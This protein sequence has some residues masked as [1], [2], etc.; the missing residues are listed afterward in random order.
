MVHNIYDI[1]LVLRANPTLFSSSPIGTSTRGEQKP[2]KTDKFSP[3]GSGSV[4]KFKIFGF[5][6]RNPRVVLILIHSASLKASL[7]ISPPSLLSPHSL[8]PNQPPSPPYPPPPYP[9]QRRRRGFPFSSAS[10]PSRLPQPHP[11]TLTYRV[12][13]L[14]STSC[15][16]TGASTAALTQPHHPSHRAPPPIDDNQHISALSLN[17]NTDRRSHTPIGPSHRMY[18]V[19]IDRRR[20]F[21]YSSSTIL[22]LQ[23]HFGRCSNFWKTLLQCLLLKGKTTFNS[24]TLI[25]RDM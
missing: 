3:F 10:P 5:R 18:D 16:A 1:F 20:K 13:L 23:V 21:L 11:K 8:L 25:C 7:S 17:P 24:E 12:E 4:T 9:A 6:V 15:Y 19:G 14:L 2:E 22:L